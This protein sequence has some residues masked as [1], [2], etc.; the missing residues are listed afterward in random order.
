MTIL[1]VSIIFALWEL[2]KAI[3]GRER[4]NDAKELPGLALIILMYEIPYMAWLVWLLFHDLVGALLIWTISLI[5]I[6]LYFRNKG[7]EARFHPFNCVF[8]AMILVGIFAGK[9]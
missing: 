1:Q 9:I 7:A 4:L 3:I 2:S 8:S 6:V 5:S